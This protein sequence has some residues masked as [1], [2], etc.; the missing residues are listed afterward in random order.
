MRGDA[1]LDTWDSNLQGGFTFGEFFV[2][3]DQCVIDS[4]TESQRLEPKTME[5]LLYLAINQGRVVSRNELIENV[6]QTIVND[7]VLSR[8]ISLLRPLDL[9]RS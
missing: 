6:W 3:P 5:V 7:E 4:G 2:R 8:A 9:K 1:L